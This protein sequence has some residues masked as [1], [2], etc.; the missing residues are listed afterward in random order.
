MTQQV[1][2]L[3]GAWLLV[4]AVSVGAVAACEAPAHRKG[5]DWLPADEKSGAIYTESIALSDFLPARMV[6]LAEA[7]R[8]EYRNEPRYAVLIF[9]SHEAAKCYHGEMDGETDWTNVSAQERRCLDARWSDHQLHAIYDHRFTDDSEYLLLTPLGG[10]A[11]APQPSVP[12]IRIDLPAAAIPPCWMRLSNRCV[13]AMDLPWYSGNLRMT[14][15]GTVTL[16]AHVNR[17]GIPEDI[18]VAESRDM[19]DGE[20]MVRGMKDNLKTWRFERA[21]RPTTIRVT[22]AQAS[23]QSVQDS[24]HMDFDAPDHFTIRAKPR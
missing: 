9:S 14:S 8:A 4:V 17:R 23:D 12:A 18:T 11:V 6:C 16:T 7:L 13:V 22:Y 24:I 5:K 1:V 3:L 20:A 15:A 10:L 2:R 21:W 19:I